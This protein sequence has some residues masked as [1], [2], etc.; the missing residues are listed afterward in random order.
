[1]RLRIRTSTPLG[2]SPSLPSTSLRIVKRIA[3]FGGRMTP[4]YPHKLFS[5]KRNN[6]SLLMLTL[7][8]DSA[9]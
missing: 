7:A 8:M 6:Y 9:N 5:D 4:D 2:T 3:I 1:P